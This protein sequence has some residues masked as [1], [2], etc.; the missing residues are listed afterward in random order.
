MIRTYRELITIPTFEERFRY[1]KLDG[2]LGVE[3][4]G[5][6]RW[7]NQ[8]FYKSYLWRN[9]I[10]PEIISRDLGRDLAVPMC[11]I[12]NYIIVHHLNPI[13]EDDIKDHSDKLTDFDNLICVSLGTHNAIHYGNINSAPSYATLERSPNDTCPWRKHE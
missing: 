9:E 3:T 13:S 1:C 4:F 6:K 8:V 7:L 2:E 11:D 5:V 10:R 12:G